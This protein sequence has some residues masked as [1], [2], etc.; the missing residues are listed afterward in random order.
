M[1]RWDIK[2]NMYGI[3]ENARVRTELEK[4]LNPPFK[5]RLARLERVDGQVFAF[6]RNLTGEM[7]EA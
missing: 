6:K 1:D 2:P 5:T 7:R 4:C 3:N